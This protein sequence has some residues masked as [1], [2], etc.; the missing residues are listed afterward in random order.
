LPLLFAFHSV[1]TDLFHPW[2]FLLFCSPVFSWD[3]DIEFLPA[4]PS[5]NTASFLVDCAQNGAN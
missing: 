4:K 3:A 1:S 2:L 5:L